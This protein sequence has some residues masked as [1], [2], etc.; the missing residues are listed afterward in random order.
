MKKL[1][2]RF[3][4]VCEANKRKSHPKTELACR[5]MLQVIGCGFTVQLCISL[6]SRHFS[7]TDAMFMEA[8]KSFD[9]SAYVAIA[10]VMIGYIKIRK[11]R[12]Q[13]LASA[14]LFCLLMALSSQLVT[15]IPV[16]IVF[17]ADNNMRQTTIFTPITLMFISL[18]G[19][20]YNLTAMVFQSVDSDH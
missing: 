11:S 7:P 4:E 14:A 17:G 8:I 10:M 13:H 19:I 9:A 12:S 18:C 3:C 6:I 5:F 20:T 15:L 2:S 16:D 1:L